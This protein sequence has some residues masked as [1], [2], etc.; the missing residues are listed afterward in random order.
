MHPSRK[1]IFAGALALFALVTG[2]AGAAP[3]ILGLM[4]SNGLPTPMRCADGICT[5]FLTSFC[6]QEVRAAPNE[7]QEYTPSSGGLRLIISRPDGSH[8]AVPGDDLLTLRLYSGLATVQARLPA[9]KLASRG[10]S[11]G[12][13]D[14]ISIDVGTGAAMLPVAA[15]NDPDPQTPQEIALATGPLRRLAA[16]TF[17]D[18]S[19]MPSTARLLGLLINAL[20]AEG[21]SRPVQLGALLRQIETQASLSRLSPEALAD[22]AVIVKNCRP[23]PAT[24]LAQGFCLESSQHGLI[25]TLN[26]EYWAAAGGS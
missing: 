13:T 24:A 6:L 4:A 23:F 25:S 21:D 3:Q 2:R 26:E 16:A 18:S 19:E 12:A 14:V 10:V 1:I 9:A 7:G 11:L 8:L 20:P 5:A 17:D 22:A 15:A